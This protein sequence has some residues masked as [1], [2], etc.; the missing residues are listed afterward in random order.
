[1]NGLFFLDREL[2]YE[3][4]DILMGRRRGFAP[5]H[6]QEDAMGNHRKALC[7]FDYVFKRF[8]NWNPNMVRDFISLPLL[9]TMKVDCLLRYVRFPPE[10]DPNKDLAY[11]A[12]LLYSETRTLTPRELALST[13][14]DVLDGRLNKFP[15]GFFDGEAGRLRLKNCLQY[16]I[17]Q[18]VPVSNIAELYGLFASKKSKGIL[19]RYRILN[20]CMDLYDSPLD[21]LHDALANSQKDECR[22]LY[23]K[24]RSVN[25]EY[26]ARGCELVREVETCA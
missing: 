15:K 14:K 1:M 17:N 2:M 13:Y 19:K 11:L 18:Y 26:A 23:L 24:Y 6:F 5:Y 20:F 3:Y 22:Y 25:E 8:L 9:R 16:M 7:M 10:A 21:L 12:W 4:N